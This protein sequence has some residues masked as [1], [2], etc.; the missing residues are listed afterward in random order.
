MSVTMRHRHDSML[1]LFLL[2][3][4]C[5]AL[6]SSR[7]A[8]AEDKEPSVGPAREACDEPRDPVD[9]CWD[10]FEPGEW[11]KMTQCLQDSLKRAEAALADSLAK[12]AQQAAESLDKIAAKQTLQESNAQWIKYRDAECARQQAFVAGR[13]HPDIGELTCLI[14]KTAQRIDDMNFDE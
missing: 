4:C 10:G 11:G 13:N 1:A 9:V 12:A 14:R 2:A 8:R 3:V 5:L 7:P 6:G